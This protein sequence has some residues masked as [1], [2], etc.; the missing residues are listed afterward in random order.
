MYYIYAQTMGDR[1]QYGIVGAAA[2]EDYENGIIK[3]HELTRPDKEE[4]RM[5]LTK[6]LNANIAP[7]F[8][9]YN[10]VPEIDTIV[11]KIVYA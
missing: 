3:K 11:E 4:D 10:A 8:F 7:V 6:H 1:T 9:T 2:C 5:I